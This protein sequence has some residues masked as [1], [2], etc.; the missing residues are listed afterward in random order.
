MAK[1]VV[2]G[3]PKG[4]L[5]DRTA[6]TWKPDDGTANITTTALRALATKAGQEVTFTAVPPGSGT[7]IAL[8]R[9]LDGKLDGQ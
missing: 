5:Y 3:K 8:D 7:R 4:F 9:N 1:P 6:G 2:G